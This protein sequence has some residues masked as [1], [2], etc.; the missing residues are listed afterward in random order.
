L[1]EQGRHEAVVVEGDDDMGLFFAGWRDGAGAGLA[2]HQAAASSSDAVA[3]VSVSVSVANRLLRPAESMVTR[4]MVPM[5]D[6]GPSTWTGDS[7]GERP[8]IC[9][10][11]R[12]VR[13]NNT[14]ASMPARDSWK[15]RWESL[16][17]ACSRARRSPFTSSSSWGRDEAGVPGRGL[18]L[19][20]K[21][22]A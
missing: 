8:T 21:A 20:E 13:S 1:A 6:C 16:I 15:R 18:Y 14:S 9:P 2:W 7:H 11:W 3:R 19:N 4:A 5:S 22:E 12:P 17:A 10:G